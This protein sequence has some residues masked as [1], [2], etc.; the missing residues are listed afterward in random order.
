MVLHGELCSREGGLITVLKPANFDKLFLHIRFSMP[1]SLGCWVLGLT[2]SPQSRQLAW[3]AMFALGLAAVASAAEATAPTFNKE[4]APILFKN[5]VKCHRP[6]EIASAVSLQSYDTAR[7]W[8]KSIKEKVLL[9]EMPPWPADPDGSLKFRN[10]ARLSRRDIDTLVAWVNAG[11]PKGNDADLPRMPTFEQGWLHPQGLVP[12][13]VVSLPGEVHAPAKGEIP[14]MRY[15]AKLNFSEDKWI[16]AS[17][18]RPGNRVLVH[19]MAITELALADG[20]TPADLDKFALLARQLGMP[21]RL[22]TTRPAVTAPGNPAL[23]D[24]LGVYVPGTTFEMYGDGSA[25][26]LKGGKNLYLNFNIHYQT[27]GKPETDRSM[28]GFWFQPSPPKHQLFRVPASGETIIA[29]GQELLTDAPGKKAEGTRM[30]I[31]PIPPYADNYPVTG[32]TAYTEPVT[33]YQFQ[34]HAHLRGKD[35]TYAI[36]YPDG[37]EETLLRVPK[38]DFNWQL[39]YELDTP[40]KLPAG[41]KLVVTAHYDNS[42]KNK[43]NPGPEKEVYFREENQSWDEMFTPFI[44]YTIDSQDLT[45]LAKAGREE[46]RG[47]NALDIAEVVGCLEPG[48]SPTWT[49]ASASDPLTFKIQATSSVA[50]K[51]AAAKPLGN[52]R[53]QLLGVG[54]FDPSSHKGQKVAVKGVLI[55]DA[56]ESRL[57]VTSLQMVAAR[58]F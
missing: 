22:S 14:Y 54:V 49:L 21:N 38:Y 46:Q 51:A 36:V 48:P 19:H 20:V 6:G 55:K 58:C 39:A 3:V 17:Q 27:T 42:L 24:M 47:Q 4:V 5:C 28:I 7:P 50:L 9:R 40:L 29:G 34:P 44:Q 18:T 30:V 35:F 15:L 57:N 8:A 52:R 45:E 32:I 37:R 31:P 33:I 11:A 13:L 16:V 26:M 10:D 56:G 53:Y 25:K 2:T 41:S 23:F 43:Y 12:D 1:A